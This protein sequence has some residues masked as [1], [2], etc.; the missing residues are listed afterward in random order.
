MFAFHNMTVILHGKT[1]SNFLA[2]KFELFLN[3]TY[4]TSRLKIAV[5]FRMIFKQRNEYNYKNTKKIQILFFSYK[6]E[7]CSR[8]CFRKYFRKIMLK[9]AGNVEEHLK[10]SSNFNKSRDTTN[11]CGDA[12]F[13]R[14]EQIS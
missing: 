7:I 10:S 9:V 6:K 11:K 13:I 12:R 3:E 14:Q 4:R 2:F 1:D 5:K 8:E